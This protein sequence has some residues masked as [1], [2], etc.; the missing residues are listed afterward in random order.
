M[1]HLDDD[2]LELVIIIAR[3]L[4]LRH[5]TFVFGGDFSSP[6]QLLQQGLSLLEEFREAIICSDS[7]RD[8]L[9]H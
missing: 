4:W 8:D 6:F 1:D 5:N 9:T 3:R 2:N 7:V